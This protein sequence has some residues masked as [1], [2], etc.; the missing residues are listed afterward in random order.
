VS[1]VGQLKPLS[2]FEWASVSQY[3]IYISSVARLVEVNSNDVVS[4]PL[5]KIGPKK[6]AARKERVLAL[7]KSN[8]KQIERFAG[9]RKEELGDSEMSVLRSMYLQF[10]R[11]AETVEEHLRIARLYEEVSGAEL[12]SVEEDED[13][14]PF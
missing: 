8:E 3:I 13:D 5:A 4:F 12:F 2:A 14:Y 11:S 1:D 10:K 6:L 7:L 9:A